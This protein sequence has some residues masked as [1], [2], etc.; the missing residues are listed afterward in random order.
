MSYSVYLGDIDP[1]NTIISSLEIRRDFMFQLLMRD[2]IVISDS[3]FL[4][5]PRINHLMQEFEDDNLAK[6]R[7]LG[8]LEQWQKGFEYL[9]NAGLVEVAYRSR[10]GSKDSITKTWENMADNDT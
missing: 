6:I 8:E 9:I 3:Q 5:D 10:N 2:S 1:N 4:T 7:E